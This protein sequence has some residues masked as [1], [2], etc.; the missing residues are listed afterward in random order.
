ML[1]IEALHE[2]N[3]VYR[4]LK[5]ENIL[6]DNE[7]YAKLCDFGFAKK[8]EGARQGATDRGFRGLT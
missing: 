3:N 6:L 1:A 2:K 7:G 8:I 5:P 4:D